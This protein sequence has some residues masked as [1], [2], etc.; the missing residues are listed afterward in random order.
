MKRK[1]KNPLTS[2]RTAN[3][4]GGKT[5]FQGK[6]LSKS[7]YLIDFIGDLDEAC[8]F[9]GK[10]PLELVSVHQKKLV[11]VYQKIL[12]EIGAM[13]HSPDALANY[14]I[15]LTTY[16]KAITVQIEELLDNENLPKLNGFII[17][18]PVNADAMI[19]RAIVRRAERSAV[20]AELTW[21]IPFLNALSDYLF[22]LAWGKD[23]SNQWVGFNTEK[24]KKNV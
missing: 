19:A 24:V 3:G 20:R 14:Q 8:A 17:P 15:N 21:A 5:A 7:H 13:T 9:M 2:I 6:Q 16:V 18:N 4:D 11:S 23:C 10:L 12:F 22:I 1:P